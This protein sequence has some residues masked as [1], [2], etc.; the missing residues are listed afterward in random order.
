MPLS[1]IDGKV[2]TMSHTVTSSCECETDK[3]LG[4]DRSHTS[5]SETEKSE[6]LKC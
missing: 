1:L 3:N 4:K 5:A 2:I 6:L